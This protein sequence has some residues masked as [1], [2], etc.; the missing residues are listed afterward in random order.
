VRRK[1]LA[2]LALSRIIS[3][4]PACPIRPSDNA[5]CDSC[6]SAGVLGLTVPP[7]LLVAADK[8]SARQQRRSLRRSK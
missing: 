8:Q 2:S 7:G 4:Q 1:S 5:P 3:V 6:G